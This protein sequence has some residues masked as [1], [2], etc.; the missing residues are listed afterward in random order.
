MGNLSNEEAICTR[1][2]ITGDFLVVKSQPRNRNSPCS[3]HDSTENKSC[4][5]GQTSSA[6]VVWKFAEERQFRCRPHHLTTVQYCEVHSKIALVL[7]QNG[8]LM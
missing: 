7:P 3:T 6:G 5:G 2:T 8:T 4:I 1:H